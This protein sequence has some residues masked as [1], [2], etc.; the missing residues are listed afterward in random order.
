MLYFLVIALCYMDWMYQ[1]S[2]ESFNT[3]FLKAINNT[4]EKGE[5]RIGKLILNIRIEIYQWISRG[6]F[7]RHKLIFLS[8]ITFR[9]M[10][11]K[12]IDVAFEQAEMDFLVKCAP[13]PGVPNTLDWLPTVAWDSV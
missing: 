11:K 4:K 7:E 9:L 13:K 2:L 6:L 10:Q 1:Y 8:L 3:F 12:N 5:E